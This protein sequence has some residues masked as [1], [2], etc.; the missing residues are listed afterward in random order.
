M[1]KELKCI[2]GGKIMSAISGAGKCLGRKRLGIYVRGY[3]QRPYII[4]TM[5]SYTLPK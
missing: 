2:L 1:E 3:N 4:E 5:H